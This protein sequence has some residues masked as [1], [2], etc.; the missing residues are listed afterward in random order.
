MLLSGKNIY[1]LDAKNRFSVPGAFFSRGRKFFLTLGLDG[2]IFLYPA[3]E[4]KKLQ[5]RITF[6]DYFRSVN[7]KFLRI[8]FA[9]SGEI[10]ADSHNRLLIPAELKKKAGIRKEIVLIKIGG[11]FEIWDPAKFMAYEKANRDTYEQLAE[12][13]DIKI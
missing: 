9:W 8:F 5:D 13:L 2:C 1:K 4:W 11:W 6:S 3:E 7:R 10:T 12:K